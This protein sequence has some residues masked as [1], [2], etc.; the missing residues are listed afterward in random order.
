MDCEYTGTSC[1]GSN[2]V[3]AIGYTSFNMAAT[4]VQASMSYT[5]TYGS[6]HARI[7]QTAVVNGATAETV[8][9]ND[10]SAAPCRNS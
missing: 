10:P 3:T 2:V 6:D 7:I 1:T 9:V 8:Y 5:L 4:V